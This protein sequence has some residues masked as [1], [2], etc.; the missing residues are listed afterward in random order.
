MRINKKIFLI[1]CFVFVFGS[2]FSQISENQKLLRVKLWVP[3][4]ENPQVGIPFNSEDGLYSSAMT[5]LKNVA[6][7][8][9]SSMIY[10]WNFEYTPSDKTRN[11]EEFFSLELL[12]KI[13]REDSNINFVDFSSLDTRFYAW[14][15][16][17]RTEEMMISRE[18][19]NSIKFP[20][21]KGYGESSALKSD[22]AI[23]EAI[24]DAA[25]NAIRTYAQTQTKNKPKEVLGKIILVDQDI[26]VKIHKGKYTAYLDFFLYVDKI[27][28]YS[29]F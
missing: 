7:Y 26:S 20:K 29:Q 21:V 24:N 14:L 3:I 15:Q 1:A 11:V 27:I 25:K 13:S 6:P 18:R 22:E 12:A 4:D 9:L 19:W 10:G 17:P 2:L 16:Y 5:S 8:I 23:I 28:Q